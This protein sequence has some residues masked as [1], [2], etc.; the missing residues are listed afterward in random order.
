MR[1]CRFDDNRLGVIDGSIVRDVT[2]ALDVLPRQG[3]PFPSHDLLVE[4]LDRV[5]ERARTLVP[6]ARAFAIDA[7]TLLSPVANPGKIVA[8]PVNYEKN[9][10]EATKDPALHGNNPGSAFNIHS[11]GLFLKSTSS[12]VGPGQGVVIRRLDRRTDHEVEL[13]I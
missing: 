7:V 8:A 13:V 6:G 1:L 4:H 2:S 9:R 5:M 3:Y 12:L 10:V 11:A